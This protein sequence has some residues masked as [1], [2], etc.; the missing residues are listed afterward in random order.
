[1]FIIFINGTFRL[2][3]KNNFIIIYLNSD[4]IE[5]LIEDLIAN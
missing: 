2:N 4:L 5:Y 1:M 3:L